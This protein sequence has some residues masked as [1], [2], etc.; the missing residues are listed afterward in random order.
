MITHASADVSWFSDLNGAA[1]IESVGD[2]VPGMS[3]CPRLHL[4]AMVLLTMAT[5]SRLG[6]AADKRQNDATETRPRQ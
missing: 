5:R 2:T 1:A 6:E 3:S 4:V